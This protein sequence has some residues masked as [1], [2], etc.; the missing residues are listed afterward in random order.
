MNE[1]IC[2]CHQ[3][4]AKEIAADARRHGRSLILEKIMAEAKK[5]NCDCT[6][7]NPKGR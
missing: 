2:F 6:R 4:S 1:I 7:N 3:F 5:G